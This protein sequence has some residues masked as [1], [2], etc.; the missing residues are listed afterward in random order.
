MTLPEIQSKRHE[1]RE[2]ISA[3]EREERHLAREE[4]AL[5]LEKL[6]SL[7]GLCFLDGRYVKRVIGIP[8]Y[9]MSMTE[10]HINVYQIPVL[11]IEVESPRFPSRE[12]EAPF[13]FDT[14]FSRAADVDD[15][16]ERFITEYPNQI[17][18]EQF[19]EIF[20]DTA[21]VFKRIYL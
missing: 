6:K 7:I 19:Q 8:H 10:K 5:I 21:K 1:L 2:Q 13:D 16:V 3:L 12:P 15:P 11:T 17:S 9:K 4:D 20:D 18:P 14:V